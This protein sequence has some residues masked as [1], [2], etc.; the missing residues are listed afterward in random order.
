MYTK[1]KN[2]MQSADATQ[3][4][5]CRNTI[6]IRRDMTIDFYPCHC[7]VHANCLPSQSD[8]AYA[9][10]DCPRCKTDSPLCSLVQSIVE[11]MLPGEDWVTAPPCKPGVL[12]SMYA[13]ISDSLVVDDRDV[14]HPRRLL[15]QHKPLPWIMQE[16]KWGLGHL[17]AMGVRLRDFLDNNYTLD[18]LCVFQDIGGQ[19]TSA[20]RKQQALIQLGLNADALIDYQHLLPIETLQRD[21]AL[22][23]ACI[24][25]PTFNG[26]LGFHPSD[27]LRSPKS[28]QWTLDNVIYL[29]YTYDDLL[30]CG[31]QYLDQWEELKPTTLHMKLL[32]APRNCITSLKKRYAPEMM[33]FDP[34]DDIDTNVMYEQQQQQQQQQPQ[35]M[36]YVNPVA[37]PVVKKTSG[38]RRQYKSK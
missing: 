32:K 15:R 34:V 21:F 37:A 23:P 14:N 30:Q 18:E 2:N 12:A 33:T 16:K 36:P 10:D 13:K 4:V 17:Y 20:Q 19:H 3:C 25:A 22:T 7:Y 5:I 24:S 31:L 9:D 6:N 11:P 28:M 27:G 1:K 8:I 35:P 29:G 26:G 38:L